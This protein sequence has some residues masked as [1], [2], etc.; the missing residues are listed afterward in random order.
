LPLTFSRL[1]RSDISQVGVTGRG[2]RIDMA[3]DGLQLSQVHAQFQHMGREDK[4]VIIHFTP[5]HG[6]WLNWIEYWFGIMGRK[7]LRESFGSP[8]E[9][10]SA[11]EAFANQWNQLLAHPF[12][13][14]YDGKGLHEKA[15]KRFTKMLQSSAG[16]MELRTLTKQ[17][18]LL[19][20]LLRD[21]SQEVSAESWQQ[22]HLALRDQSDTID[23]L[24]HHEEGPIRKINAQQAAL[25]LVIALSDHSDA[26]CDPKN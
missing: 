18:K 17:L 14:S 15:V 20:N 2:R 5:F 8:D 4:R 1:G 23:D 12:Q 22:L 19:V 25:D 7:V 16:K 9:I 21:Y 6:S 11:L 24:I 3:E 26:I 10:K 13:W